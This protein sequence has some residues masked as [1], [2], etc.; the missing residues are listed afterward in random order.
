MQSRNKDRLLM[1][2]PTLPWPARRNGTALRFAPII[3]HLADRYELDILVLGD[4]PEPR[5]VEGPL[6]KCRDVTVLAVPYLAL[7]AWLLKLRTA[8]RGLVPWGLPLGSL[9]PLAAASLQRRL[10]VQMRQGGYT[11]VLWAGFGYLDIACAVCRGRRTGR[12]VLD[13]I[14]SPALIAAREVGLA[15]HL[16]PLRRYIVWKWRRMERQVQDLCDATIYISQPDAHAA[17]AHPPPRVHVVPNGLFVGG[18]PQVSRRQTPGRVIGFLGSMAYRPNISAVL[19]LATRIMPQVLAALPDARLLVIGRSPPPEVCALQ[20]D[21]V[22][23]TGEVAEIWEHIAGADVFVFP[24]IEGAGMQNKILEVMHAGKPVVTTGISAAGIG[25][26][27][28]QQLL[29]GDSDAQIV[30]HILALLAD[31]RLA[32]ALVQ[33]AQSFVHSEFSLEPIL[34]RYEA[35]LAPPAAQLRAAES[36]ADYSRT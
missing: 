5:V 22:T 14:D 24:M 21:Q 35:I 8:F 19:R 36:A 2:L 30:A 15:P 16:L 13:M 28:G 6:L 31:P 18:Q 17:R 25:A 9:R 27:N 33:R 20:S 26:A 34:T 12:F 23:V 7:P 10:L 1:V 29:V 4:P 3:A 11:T 32:Q